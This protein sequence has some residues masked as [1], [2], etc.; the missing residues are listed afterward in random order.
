MAWYARAHVRR[1]VRL[2]QALLAAHPGAFPGVD[3]VTAVAFASLHDRSKTARDG[4]FL[5]R[6]GL[7]EPFA[8]SLHALFGRAAG[9]GERDVIDRMNE[10]DQRIAAAF[11]ARHGI[12]REA[13]QQY[14]RLVHVADLVDRGMDETSR[15]H[16]MGRVLAPASEVI[17]EPRDR[18]LAAWLEREYGRIVAHTERF[19]ALRVRLRSTQPARGGSPL[20]LRSSLLFWR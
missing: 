2:A 3:P 6:H 15:H 7:R 9:P 17:V 16:E 10:V 1:V 20:R 14:E 5:A 4:G 12:G 13:A 8:I 11:F 18:L 19:A